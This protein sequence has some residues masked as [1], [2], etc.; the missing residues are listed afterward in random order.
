MRGIKWV[1]DKVGGGG[2][3][4]GEQGGDK[5]GDKAGGGIKLE[6]DKVGGG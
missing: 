5:V 1:G 6:G 4:V 2:D 3:K